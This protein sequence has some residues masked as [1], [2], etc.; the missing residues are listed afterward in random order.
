MICHIIIHNKTGRISIRGKG[1]ALSKIL[2]PRILE[3][4][5]ERLCFRDQTQRMEVIA[6]PETP[7]DARIS[8]DLARQY[9][10]ELK[11]QSGKTVRIRRR[12]LSKIIRQLESAEQ[13]I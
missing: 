8:V 4:K 6:A 1:E 5:P 9:L 11:K 3:Q 2:P 7:A 12:E 13:S 10:K